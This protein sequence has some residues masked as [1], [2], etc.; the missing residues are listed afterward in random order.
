MKLP[1]I[2]WIEQQVFEKIPLYIIVLTTLFIGFDVYINLNIK[3]KS[4]DLIQVEQ[5]LEKH[6]RIVTEQ[7]SKKVDLGENSCPN[8]NA[9]NPN[10]PLKV[11]IFESDTCPFC[12]AQNKVFDEI[13]P[14]YGDLFYVE[15][16]ELNPCP[17]EAQRYQISGVPTFIFSARGMEKPSTYGFLDKQQLVDYICGVSKQC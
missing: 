9:G 11:K 13:L 15:W 5:A 12:V 3:N 17:E 10:A 7:F 4:Q 1:K 8:F 2:V 14:E 6:P 16:Y